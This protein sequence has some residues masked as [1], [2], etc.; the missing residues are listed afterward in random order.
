M[1]EFN[2]GM[3]ETRPP[4]AATVTTDVL[5][6]GSGPAG[7]SAALFLSTLGVDN[8]MV[9][10]YRWTANTPRAHITNQRSMEIF[11]DMGIED[12]VLAD[13]TSTRLSAIP[14]SAPR[15]PGRRSAA[16]TRGA[17]GPTGKVTTNSRRP[18][19]PSTSRRPTWSRSWSRTRHARHPGPVLH[20]IPGA[21]QDADGVEW[22]YWT[23]SAVIDYT[24]RAKY[25]IGADGARSQ[26]RRRYRIAV[27]RGRWTSPDR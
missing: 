11:R 10:K 26:D 3:A 7:A 1:A 8:I 25:V 17:P 15:S 22:T 21:P 14:C 12:Q 6:V 4:Q 18:A 24:I 16:S 20:R 13:A 23:G 19:S 2:D 27:R 5:I 9:T